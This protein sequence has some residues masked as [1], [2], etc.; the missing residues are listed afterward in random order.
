MRFLLVDL[1][2][3][4]NGSVSA[5]RKPQA[6]NV[7]QEEER[8]SEIAV[9]LHCCL[10]KPIVQSWNLGEETSAAVSVTRSIRVSVVDA[11]TAVEF[12]LC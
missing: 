12:V 11:I 6:N 10:E 9:G 3:P 4:N 5:E 2:I 7:R 8:R 1:V